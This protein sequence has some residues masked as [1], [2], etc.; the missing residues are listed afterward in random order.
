MGM[1]GKGNIP[2]AMVAGIII[3]II[4]KVGAVLWGA[5]I[6]QI[7]IFVMF[8]VILLVL[9]DGIMGIKLPK[10]RKAVG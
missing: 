6:A 1:G 10:K 4:E 5:S 2:G 7:I 9:P 8:I 3:G